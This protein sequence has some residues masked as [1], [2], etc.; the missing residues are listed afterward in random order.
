MKRTPMIPLEE[1]TAV[2]AYRRENRY[3]FYSMTTKGIFPVN[4]TTFRHHVFLLFVLALFFPSMLSGQIFGTARV[5]WSSIGIRGMVQNQEVQWGGTALLVA[6]GVGYH[7]YQTTIGD[8]EY[9]L[10][11]EAVLNY[12]THNFIRAAQEKRYGD[13][14][15]TRNGFDGGNSVITAVEIRPV[16]RIRIPSAG[17]ISPFVSAGVYWAIFS[18]TDLQQRGATT[19]IKGTRASYAGLDISYGVNILALEFVEPYLMLNHY[20]LFGSNFEPIN[21]MAAGSL[22]S[23]FIAS[24]GIR[25]EL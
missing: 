10:E 7:C 8:I 14:Y 23:T 3:I 19:T 2:V 1:G 9:H 18:T 15:F 13:D 22:P 20:F 16:H 5:G 12:S 24:V 6:G 4:L 11:L 25:F 21:G 17:W